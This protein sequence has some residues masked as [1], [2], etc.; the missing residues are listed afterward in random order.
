MNVTR[1]DHCF[2]ARVVDHGIYSTWFVPGIEFILLDAE[3]LIAETSLMQQHSDLELYT[4][5]Q[6]L[7]VSKCWTV[8]EITSALLIEFGV[9]ISF[10]Y[11]SNFISVLRGE[12][13][14][15]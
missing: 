7:A 1:L 14:A 3:R 2:K 4:P 8:F 9:S 15:E 10:G 11:R 6:S 5:A 12:L 13:V